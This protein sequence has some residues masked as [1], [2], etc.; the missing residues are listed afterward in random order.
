MGMARFER[1]PEGERCGLPTGCIVA[2]S[3]ID[4]APK[5]ILDFPCSGSF[6]SLMFR[7]HRWTYWLK[8]SAIAVI[9]RAFGWY[10]TK[11]RLPGGE[12]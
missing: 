6:I 7:H 3:G 10:G 1:S 9:P 2:A 8:P 11:L 4:A 12:K 5:A